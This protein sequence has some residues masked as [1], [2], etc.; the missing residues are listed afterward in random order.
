MI[1]LWLMGEISH[2]YSTFFLKKN[3]YIHGLKH[4]LSV[5]LYSIRVRHFNIFKRF[6]DKYR[7]TVSLHQMFYI[8]NQVL[9]TSKN[10]HVDDS[11]QSRNWL[12][13]VK[14]LHFTICKL[15]KYPFTIFWLETTLKL[16]II[17]PLLNSSC[18]IE[19]WRKKVM[20]KTFPTS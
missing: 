2:L 11:L 8:W 10:L 20:L 15:R 5:Q 4:P 13:I 16:L 6:C 7:R 18:L 3:I 9:F 17:D 19:I 1:G 12:N 14:E